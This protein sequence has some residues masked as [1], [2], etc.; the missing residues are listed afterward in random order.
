[1]LRHRA[2]SLNL[3]PDYDPCSTPMACQQYAA[4]TLPLTSANAAVRTGKIS[5]DLTR[6]HVFL[7]SSDHEADI[8]RAT[9]QYSINTSSTHQVPCFIHNPVVQ[10]FIHA[11]WRACMHRSTFIHP[12]W[13]SI[14]SF[15][16]PCILLFTHFLFDVFLLQDRA[17]EDGEPGFGW[18]E[19]I[20]WLEPAHKPPPRA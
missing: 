18:P 9:C 11:C 17:R 4:V 8:R 19:C 14:H 2:T 15:V 12:F 13:I 16:R 5:H 6:L 10:S 1:V 20:P 7:C 3:G